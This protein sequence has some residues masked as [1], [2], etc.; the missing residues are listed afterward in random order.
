MTTF[1]LILIFAALLVLDFPKVWKR[2]GMA[3]KIVYSSILGLA[4]VLSE[5]NILG[6]KVIG[7][8]QILIKI[9]R[10]IGFY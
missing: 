3:A 6:F 5:L 1:G 2:K 8:N 7:L 9:I 4:F 10:L